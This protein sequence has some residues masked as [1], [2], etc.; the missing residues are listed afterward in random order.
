[1]K[2]FFPQ[3]TNPD[4]LLS[5]SEQQ[6]SKWVWLHSPLNAIKAQYSVYYFI[7]PI[8]AFR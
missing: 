2:L 1:M 8:D 6:H 7:F 5:M 4:Q 3:L